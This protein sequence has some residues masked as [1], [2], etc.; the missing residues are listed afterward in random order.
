[1]F[2]FFGALASVKAC[3]LV[4][5]LITS[6]L[7]VWCYGFRIVKGQLWILKTLICDCAKLYDHEPL[8]I[9][10]FSTKTKS[11]F[12]NIQLESRSPLPDNISVCVRNSVEE[13]S[14]Y[15]YKKSKKKK[16][17]TQNPCPRKIINTMPLPSPRNGKC[18][19]CMWCHRSIKEESLSCEWC[20][21]SMHKI[22]AEIYF[23]RL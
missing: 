6:F 17:Q 12:E 1:M 14:F 2:C 10:F 5:V 3:G 16:S 4:N 19:D 22:C 23:E 21:E 20:G 13:M 15:Q 11:S 7:L 9:N 18:Q 8:T